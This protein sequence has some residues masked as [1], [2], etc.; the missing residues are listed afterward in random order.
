MRFHS[1]DLNTEDPIFEKV[2]GDPVE[3][4]EKMRNGL[5]SKIVKCLQE[6]KPNS[7]IYSQI[8]N[9]LSEFSQ[10]S[11]FPFVSLKTHHI[12]TQILRDLIETLN[13]KSKD[14]LRIK[15]LYLLKIRFPESE[16][17]RLK[18]LR[19]FI[20]TRNSVVTTLHNLLNSKYPRIGDELL[21]LFLTDEQI[22]EALTKLYELGAPCILEIFECKV[23]KRD[24][25]GRLIYLVR[26]SNYIVRSINCSE[27]LGF[28]ERVSTWAKMLEEREE[29]A[30]LCISLQ[31][32]IHECVK[33]FLEIVFE[34]LK[35]KGK[36]LE[37]WK[38]IPEEISP[39]LLIAFAEGY[40]EFLG[41]VK[42]HLGKF[43]HINLDEFTAVKSI[44]YF[45]V[46]LPVQDREKSLEAYCSI[47][48]LK[49][50]LRFKSLTVSMVIADRKYPFWRIREA[51]KNTFSWIVGESMYS[52]SDEDVEYLRRISG[53][54]KEASKSQLHN[55]ISKCGMIG[56]ELKFFLESRAKQESCPLESQEI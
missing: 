41:D 13:V 48:E 9:L 37:E 12:I 25:L 1:I 29:V 49:K 19:E 35:D 34:E 54:M 20:N 21:A 39:D 43:F 10:D 45:L 33:E 23:E 30:W 17:H 38:E 32:P 18:E 8:N 55:I 11:R 15:K 56:K 22:E 7:Q 36:E 4:D 47:L 40:S 6:K 53:S 52:L 51:F 50:K 5:W 46:V 44:D 27:D 16:F 2:Y 26:D 14:E 31:K 42:E 28:K 24:Y 3:F